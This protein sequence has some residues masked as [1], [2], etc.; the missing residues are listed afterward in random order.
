MYH[1]VNNC[2]SSQ[3]FELNNCILNFKL[4]NLSVLLP[5]NFPPILPT[6]PQPTKLPSALSSFLANSQSRATFYFL[7]IFFMIRSRETHTSQI[8]CYNDVLFLFCLSLISQPPPYLLYCL[9]STGRE[10]NWSGEVGSRPPII[11]AHLSQ[12]TSWPAD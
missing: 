3:R 7:S 5:Q 10:R 4:P 11:S 8:Y 1:I 9:L 12:T 2:T 6:L